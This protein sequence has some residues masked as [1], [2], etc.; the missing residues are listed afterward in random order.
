MEPPRAA[1][2]LEDVR[3]SEDENLLPRKEKFKR[4]TFA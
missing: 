3:L 2:S 1:A 4:S